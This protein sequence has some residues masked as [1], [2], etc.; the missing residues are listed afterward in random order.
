MKAKYLIAC[1]LYSDLGVSAN[2]NNPYKR[3]FILE[4][5][6]DELNT[7]FIHGQLSSEL[8]GEF[9]RYTGL[10]INDIKFISSK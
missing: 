1:E 6:Y 5:S 3:S 10:I 7:S 8:N 9:I 4:L 2:R